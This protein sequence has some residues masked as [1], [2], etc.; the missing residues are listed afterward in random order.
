MRSNL[1]IFFIVILFNPN[2][3]FGQIIPDTMSIQDTLG[4]LIYREMSEELPGCKEPRPVIEFTDT[5]FLCIHINS[6]PKQVCDDFCIKLEKDGIH[7][8]RSDYPD[9]I[10]YTVIS[11]KLTNN[12]FR[13]TFTGSIEYRCVPASSFSGYLWQE[14][15]ESYII[16]DKYKNII[17]YITT[18]DPQVGGC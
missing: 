13:E 14:Y 12:Q 11:I 9:E 6:L 17:K 3:L 18:T 8:L 4:R 15:V 16:P 10:D 2:A 1:L 7:I 5:I